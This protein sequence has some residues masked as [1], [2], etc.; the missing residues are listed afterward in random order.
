MVYSSV[1]A[2]DKNSGVPHFESKWETE[3]Y[4]AASGLHYS[5]IRPVYFMENLFFPDTI[6]DGVFY[7]AMKPTDKLQAIAA[8]DIGAFA[9]I[10]FEKPDLLPNKAIEIAGDE[11]TMQEWTNVIGAKKFQEVPLE[12]LPHE[13]KVM[14]KFFQDVGYGANVAEC[15]KLYPNLTDLKTWADKN[16]KH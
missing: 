16:L 13:A 15:K 10:A 8:D 6:K 5:T 11:L 9:A 1:G 14:F 4:L 7:Q 12:V 3:K 2:A